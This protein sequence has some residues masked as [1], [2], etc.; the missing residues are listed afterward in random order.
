MADLMADAQS[1]RDSLN[2]Y[3]VTSEEP[4]RDGQPGL[5]AS[6]CVTARFTIFWLISDFRCP[7]SMAQAGLEPGRSRPAARG[8]AVSIL[9]RLENC[10][11]H[12]CLYNFFAN[13]L[14]PRLAGSGRY[15]PKQAIA[16][17]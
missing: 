1:A 6:D 10:S 11:R 14:S 5:A 4:I 2:R 7:S 17:R 16:V 8:R 12:D 15:N 9:A 3:M 13:A